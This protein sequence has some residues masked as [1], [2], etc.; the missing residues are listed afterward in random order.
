M[1]RSF[2]VVLGLAFVV[3]LIDLVVH[4]V[5]GSSEASAG[6]DVR[7]FGNLLVGFF[8]GLGTCALDRLGGVVDGVLDR[9]H[10]D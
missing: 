5:F 4:G 3:V 8:G 7:V 10:C 1:L 2:L 6:P 9:I